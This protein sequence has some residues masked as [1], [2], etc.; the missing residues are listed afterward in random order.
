MSAQPQI[1]ER[2]QDQRLRFCPMCD[3]MIPITE[4]GISRARK[5]GLNRY[6]RPHTRQ[7]VYEFRQRHKGYRQAEWQRK[8]AALTAARQ[9]SVEPEPALPPS[10]TD[11]VFE[12]LQQH[13]EATQ[14]QIHNSTKL[15]LGAID[16]ALTELLI[17]RRVISTRALSD[18]TRI[19]FLL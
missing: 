5:D 1:A 13:G 14:K 2:A 11:L 4:F 16:I 9:N 10:T 8:N 17:T 18:H 15:A 6:C 19:Y 3:A 12:F 7:Q